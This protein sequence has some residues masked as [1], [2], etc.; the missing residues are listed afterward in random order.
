MNDWLGESFFS[1]SFWSVGLIGRGLELLIGNLE[2]QSS[3]LIIYRKTREDIGT[4]PARSAWQP[5]FQESSPDASSLHSKK[6]LKLSDV[7]RL[8]LAVGPD[9]NLRTWLPPKS[10]CIKLLL[11]GIC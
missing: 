1:L 5:H 8:L 2:F 11:H 3:N 9:S 7:A 6:L 10:G 4:R